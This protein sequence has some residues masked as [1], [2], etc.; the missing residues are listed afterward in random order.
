MHTRESFHERSMTL[1]D[2]L[3]QGAV[4]MHVHV[5]PHLKSSPRRVDP[6][7]AAEQARAA[8]MR[9]IVYMDVFMN[10]SGTAW[11]VKQRVP[12]IEVFGG[13]LLNTC[14]G[15][16][17]PR[18]VKTAIQYGTGASFV[19]FGTHST[20][21]QASREARL[22]DGK[23]VAFHDLYPEF[24]QEELSRAIRIPLEDPI[25]AE[26]EE[27]LELVGRN[28][29]MFLNTGHVSGE[30]ALRVVD[31]A[32]DFGIEK[33]LVASLAVDD[34]TF[35]QQAQAAQAGAFLERS[36]ANLVGTGGVPK[37]HYYVERKYLCEAYTRPPKNKLTLREL[38][39]QLRDIGPEHFVVDTD[40]GMRSLPT[41]VEGMRQV[42]ACLLDMEFSTEEI[43]M[44]TSWNP[45]RLLGLPTGGA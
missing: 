22:V 4:D 26:L 2:E 20:Y 10:S 17:N 24:A 25:S 1:P 28:Q 29:Q 35:E 13:L 44:M 37:T 15:G 36:F 16:L 38:G 11:L 18:A 23:P 3:L 32:Q 27:I 6:F 34:M 14:H 21:F 42:M 7:E 19:S 8:G 41:P 43:Q 45:A 31:L 5:G 39:D 12:G 9:A 33:I 40:Y 30:E